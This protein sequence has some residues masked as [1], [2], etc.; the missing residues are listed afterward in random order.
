MCDTVEPP[1]TRCIVRGPGVAGEGVG[2]ELK[3]EAGAEGRGVCV[4][5]LVSLLVLVLIL[6][7]L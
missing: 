6:V 5:I 3:G 7:L 4:L 1:P 2:A